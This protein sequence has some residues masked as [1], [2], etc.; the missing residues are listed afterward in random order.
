VSF[1]ILHATTMWCIAEL[2]RKEL[3]T[4]AARRRN[5]TY[6]LPLGHAPSAAR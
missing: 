4:A 2:V 6:A 3:D 1:L 5:Q